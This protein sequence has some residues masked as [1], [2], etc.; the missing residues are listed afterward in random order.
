MILKN[1]DQLDEY[2]IQLNKNKPA[3]FGTEVNLFG[4]PHTLDKPVIH[5]K[6]L[7]KRYL[8]DINEESYKQTDMTV[9]TSCN[10]AWKFFLFTI[11]KKN[12][13][14]KKYYDTE[15]AEIKTAKQIINDNL[16]Q[17]PEYFV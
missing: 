6:I 3:S 16:K 1:P 10:E 12:E 9:F 7:T 11:D 13:K 14:L 5:F 2:R 8:Y 17:H 4:V 15:M